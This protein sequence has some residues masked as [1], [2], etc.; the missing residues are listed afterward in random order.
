MPEPDPRPAAAD[1]RKGGCLYADDSRPVRLPCSSPGVCFHLSRRHA[2]N[3]NGTDENL[4]PNTFGCARLRV[5]DGQFAAFAASQHASHLA[6]FDAAVAPHCDGTLPR[7]DGHPRLNGIVDTIRAAQAHAL[8]VPKVF[9]RPDVVEAFETAVVDE[10]FTGYKAQ[11]EALRKQYRRLAMGRLLGDLQ[12]R[13]QSKA[14]KGEQEKLKLAL[15]SAREFARCPLASV[16]L[17]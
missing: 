12:G 5:L 10:W 15:Y 2:R 17:H 1:A 3:S 7:V 16:G 13:M 14:E 6:T 9:E 8:P 11:D 4:L